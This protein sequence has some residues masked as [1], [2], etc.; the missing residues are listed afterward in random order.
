MRLAGAEVHEALLDDAALLASAPAGAEI[1]IHAE[2]CLLKQ[3]FDDALRA[4][5]RRGAKVV[6]CFHY[7]DKDFLRRLADSSDVLVTHRDYGIPHPKVKIVPLACPVYL[8]GNSADL[9]REHG[10]PADK[11]I[12]TTLGF[13]TPWKRMVELTQHLLPLL[14]QHGMLLQILSP[15]HFSG[16]QNR[17]GERLQRLVQGKSAVLWRPNF[18]PE[19]EVLER[20]SA[21]DLGLMYHG[22]HTGSCSAASKTFVSARCPLLVTPSNH[23]SDIRDGAARVRSFDLAEFAE[24]AVELVRDASKLAALRNGMERDYERMN[25]AAVAQQYLDIFRSIAK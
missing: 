4:A 10:L 8:P 1:L 25:R 21:S 11:T 14:E 7:C 22:Q 5:H 13:L 3:G 19:E 18:L 16:D 9:R 24:R 12:L 23:D 2:P 6:T 20:A 15:T 17:E